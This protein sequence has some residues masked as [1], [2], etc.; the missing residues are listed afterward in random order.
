MAGS[1]ASHDVDRPVDRDGERGRLSA[2]PDA[3]IFSAG[4][5]PAARKRRGRLASGA[6]RVEIAA[7]DLGRRRRRAGG[8]GFVRFVG[9]P[10]FPRQARA[11]DVGSRAVSRRYFSVL[12]RRHRRRGTPPLRDGGVLFRGVLHRQISAPLPCL[13]KLTRGPLDYDWAGPRHLAVACLFSVLLSGETEL[14]G[15]APRVE[16]LLRDE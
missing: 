10:A 7:A 4:A 13:G 5:F 6:Q 1:F 16:G 8:A 14:R 9:G 15:A 12:L 2:P 3:G 11:A